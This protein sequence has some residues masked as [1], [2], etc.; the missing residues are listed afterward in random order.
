MCAIKTNILLKEYSISDIITSNPKENFFYVGTFED[1]EDPNVEWP[2]RHDFYSL[3]W[4]TKSTG[5]NVI[6]FE[7]YEIKHNRL[8]SMRPKQ[9]HNWSYSKNSK[10]YII[11]FDKY[12]LKE[13]TDFVD[14][15]FFDLSN[16]K[17][18]LLK[19]LFENLIEESKKNDQ[20][21]EK[22]IVQGISYL[23]LQLKRVSNKNPKN[24]ERK[25]KTILKFSKLVS[26]T[27]GDNLSV[28]EYASKLNLTVDKLNQI[29][30]ENYGQSPKTIILEKKITEAKRLLYFT[31][32]SVKEIAFQ[33]GFEDSS[34][35]SRIF[36][37]K[38]NLSPTEFK[39]V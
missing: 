3:V 1:T 6:D 16:K 24:K 31:D 28:N 26:D 21:S 9:V 15:P 8:F 25:S 30:K 38:T 4:F 27:I 7:E 23:L 18:Q 37:Q 17:T 11:V 20:L 12:L 32:L 13:I 10:G 19:P 36:K 39:S 14:K 29:C 5:I 33:L 2:H 35:F 34:Y 22:T